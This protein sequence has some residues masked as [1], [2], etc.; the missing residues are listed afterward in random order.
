MS[1]AINI[2][3]ALRKINPPVVPMDEFLANGWICSVLIGLSTK[4]H[5]DPQG[6]Q[7]DVVVPEVVRSNAHC[8]LGRHRFRGFREATHAKC[9]DKKDREKTHRHPHLT[10]I[11]RTFVI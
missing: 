10:R 4:L 11:R 9:S 7:I 5:A 2:M 6:S 1:A 3:I 8:L